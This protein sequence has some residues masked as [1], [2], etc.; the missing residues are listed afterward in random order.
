MARDG[1]VQASALNY[2]EGSYQTIVQKAW[3]PSD[4]WDDRWT[5]AGLAEVLVHVARAIVHLSILWQENREPLQYPKGST[6]AAI[7]HLQKEEHEGNWLRPDRIRERAI[8]DLSLALGVDSNVC[9]ELVGSLRD[10]SRMT[11]TK[12]FPDAIWIADKVGTRSGR[13]PSLWDALHTQASTSRTVKK[14]RSS[15]IHS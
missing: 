15:I 5:C 6:P 2:P 1:H 3:D 12:F 11:N 4:V 10:C 8:G 7:R 14:R 9:A 13:P